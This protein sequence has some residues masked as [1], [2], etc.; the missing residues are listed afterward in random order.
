MQL[1]TLPR[2][3]VELTATM[4]SCLSHF[5]TSPCTLNCIYLLQE[6]TVAAQLASIPQSNIQCTGR[7]VTST[8]ILSRMNSRTWVEPYQKDLSSSHPVA[9]LTTLPALRSVTSLFRMGHTHA[10]CIISSTTFSGMIPSTNDVTRNKD[11]R[12]PAVFSSTP[13]RRTRSW[14]RPVGANVKIEVTHQI[15][16]SEPEEGNKIKTNHE[17]TH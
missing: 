6:E 10:L 15:R 2:N 16:H 1:E 9:P 11:V 5:K 4:R 8:A 17:A 13:I 7:F 3:I 14:R 12:F